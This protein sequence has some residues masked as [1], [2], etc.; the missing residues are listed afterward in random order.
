MN[1]EQLIDRLYDMADRLGSQRALAQQ[2]G[3]SPSY[4]ND[5]LQ[6]NRKPGRVILQALKL[7]AATRYIAEANGGQ[8]P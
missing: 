2:L 7:K 6:G 3:V 4:L 8:K 5:V 1:R